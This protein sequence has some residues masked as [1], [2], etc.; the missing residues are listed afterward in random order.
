MKT[1]Q[2]PSHVYLAHRIFFS[3]LHGLSLGTLRQLALVPTD[4]WLVARS[5]KLFVTVLS[6]PTSLS[7]IPIGM[8][9][10]SDAKLLY[11]MCCL[12]ALHTWFPFQITP[13]R[14]FPVPITPLRPLKPQGKHTLRKGGNT[15]FLDFVRLC[16]AWRRLNHSTTVHTFSLNCQLLQL[17][18]RE[19]PALTGLRHWTV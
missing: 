4:F 1:S 17:P 13:F 7:P 12:L 10:C 5:L 6:P 11:S 8:E 18:R 3:R 2:I 15:L 9:S 14:A 16:L 19:D